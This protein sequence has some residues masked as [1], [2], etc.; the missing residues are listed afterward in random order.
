MIRQHE[1]EGEPTTGPEP[2]LLQRCANRYAAQR[3][4][5]LAAV[6]LQALD[7]PSSTRTIRQRVAD[8]LDGRAAPEHVAD[9]VGAQLEQL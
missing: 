1:P 2:F 6:F 4:S 8:A 5:A 7:E 3:L 9:V